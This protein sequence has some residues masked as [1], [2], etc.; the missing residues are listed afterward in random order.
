MCTRQF[1]AFY[2]YM[3]IVHCGYYIWYVPIFLKLICN[4]LGFWCFEEIKM[5]FLETLID[6]FTCLHDYVT[7]HSYQVDMGNTA[8]AV[9]L[10]WKTIEELRQVFL[11]KRLS[12]AEVIFRSECGIHCQKMLK[13]FRRHSEKPKNEESIIFVTLIK[14][15]E[16]RT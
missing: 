3:F 15:N 14:N 13:S 4:F 9:H 1:W 10:R 16:L 8:I 6:Y 5:I 7:M 12:E 2:T 11:L